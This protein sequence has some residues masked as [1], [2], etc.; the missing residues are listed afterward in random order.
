[1][2]L[3]KYQINNTLRFY[4]T[5]SALQL[6]C[7]NKN[8]DDGGGWNS[9]Q[10][11]TNLLQESEN[12]FVDLFPEQ[13]MFLTQND[14]NLRKI[15]EESTFQSWQSH[16]AR[17]SLV[18]D[19]I[20]FDRND[21]DRKITLYPLDIRNRNETKT[22]TTTQEATANNNNNSHN[23]SNFN[24]STV[25]YYDS[26]T[27]RRPF[28]LFQ[29]PNDTRNFDSLAAYGL[30]ER[31]PFNFHDFST[32]DVFLDNSFYDLHLNTISTSTTTSNPSVP[33]S[34][35][36][37]SSSLPSSSSSSIS[38]P[39]T[40]NSYRKSK[41]N[42]LKKDAILPN[43]NRIRRQDIDFFNSLTRE[44]NQNQTTT[45]LTTQ[46]KQEVEE[47]EEEEG[48]AA[49]REQ[50]S[51]ATMSNSIY[52]QDVDL[53]YSF[54]NMNPAYTV[55]S[56]PI[57][58]AERVEAIQ[59]LNE[60][61]NSD[62]S[63]SG[64][65]IEFLLSLAASNS[66]SSN[67][68]V[69][70]TAAISH[71]EKQLKIE[72]D[73][74]LAEILYEQD[75]DLGYILSSNGDSKESLSSSPSKSDKL[76]EKQKLSEDENSND[77]NDLW[78]GIPFKIDNETGEYIRLP[79]E[80][81]LK[82]LIPMEDDMAQ[83]LKNEDEKI[84]DEAPLS[85][86]DLDATIEDIASMLAPPE[87]YG[88][89]QNA[90]ARA[91]A[92]DNSQTP[93]VAYETQQHQ[94]YGFNSNTNNFFES[95]LEP[96]T[97][98]NPLYAASGGSTI[99]QENNNNNSD[100]NTDTDAYL[101]SILNMD[102]F[103]MMDANDQS[104]YRTSQQQNGTSNSNETPKNDQSKSSNSAGG[105]GIIP[106]FLDL[107][108]GSA[109]SSLGSLSSESLPSTSDGEWNDANES[110]NDYHQ[111]NFFGPYD[112]SSNSSSSNYTATI[113]QVPVAQKKYHMFGKR[114][115]QEEIS[116]N[117]TLVNS[118]KLNTLKV[119]NV[120]NDFDGKENST[121]DEFEEEM[122]VHANMKNITKVIKPGVKAERDKFK[123]SDPIV[124]R[125]N[126]TYALSHTLEEEH[127]ANDRDDSEYG[128]KDEEGGHL[129]R[130]EKRARNLNI[131]IPVY[132]IINL[133][134]D[135][136]N[137]R[138][139][140]H[141]LSEN[142]LSLIRDIRRRGKNKVAAQNC[143]KRKLDTILTL[144]TEVEQVRRRKEE[145]N[146]EKDY[147]A[148][149]RKRI[150]AKFAA[151]HKHIFHYLKDDEG[152]PCSPSKYS[153]QQAADGSMFL[154]P[155]LN[156]KQDPNCYSMALLMG[157]PST[158]SV[159]RERSRLKDSYGRRTKTDETKSITEL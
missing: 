20:R 59:K 1:M 94:A 62:S 67:K 122:K 153:L 52:K 82:D 134:M 108:C 11:S 80:E 95:N 68:K 110:V 58:E 43:I 32:Q 151:L 136:F 74:K 42:P 17:K 53:G 10:N 22:I 56:P 113:R 54:S 21:N 98:S 131:P 137:E 4:A 60:R 90:E 63:E 116:S 147:V 69:N 117:N 97:G 156:S 40:S 107:S 143:R 37:T 28:S 75:I 31:K 124:V 8:P 129:T 18:E 120:V 39:S 66:T 5:L 140:K 138:I 144:E 133:P 157:E 16:L 50:Q 135:E 33:S 91:Y 46:I 101:D 104:D 106:N 118:T 65:D 152:R 132:D 25:D 64:I 24:T 158:S 57:E 30:D 77:V 149:E 96:T 35:S 127:Q 115:L 146:N 128:D 92:N 29:L 103:K 78:A 126:H 154:S 14:M 48:A 79:F 71:H 12:V 121:M 112:Y 70:T 44:S 119:E 100:I 159:C 27:D 84:E 142:Q 81:I 13:S 3:R 49:M 85:P 36:L 41:R 145:L 150:A 125:H 47:A 6:L 155:R 45:T 83:D 38:M 34:S 15:L 105:N 99:N 23:V 86:L 130:D 141:D 73:R 123:N 87:F 139:A 76:S 72:E 55:L 9:E 2:I 111:S 109:G 51:L 7:F 102:C 26:Y 93:N 114:Y 148:M 89:Q 88:V 61:K 19:L